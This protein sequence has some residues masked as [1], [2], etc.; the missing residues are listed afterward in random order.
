MSVFIIKKGN[1]FFLLIYPFNITFN[2]TF[3]IIRINLF[4]QSNK[5]SKKDKFI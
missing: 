5:K 2:I 1:V 3:N 4:D